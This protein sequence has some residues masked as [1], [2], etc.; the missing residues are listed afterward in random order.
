MINKDKL[1][2]AGVKFTAARYMGTIHDF[3]I[4]NALTNTL[5]TRG[6]ISQA[7]TELKEALK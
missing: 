1:F 4:L 5:A 2:Q 6:A 7:V 3:V